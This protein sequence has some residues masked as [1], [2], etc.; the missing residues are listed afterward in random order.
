MAE[1]QK[2]RGRQFDPGAVDALLKLTA[3]HDLLQ[4][5]QVLLDETGITTPVV[6]EAAPM[7]E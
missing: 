6:I 5:D 2:E 4:L 3:A 7:I 1:I